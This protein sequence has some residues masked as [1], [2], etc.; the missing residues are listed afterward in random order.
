VVRRLALLVGVCLVTLAEV[1]AR[2]M[3]S[4]PALSKG[5]LRAFRL[6]RMPG[7]VP[8]SACWAVVVVGASA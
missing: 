8:E 5:R 1:V 3:M 2:V 4:V 7:S 6:R